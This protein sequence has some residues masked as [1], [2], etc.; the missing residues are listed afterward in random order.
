MCK[1]GSLLVDMCG[2]KHFRQPTLE[3]LIKQA[4]CLVNDQEL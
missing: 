1:G 4:I 3:R 2:L